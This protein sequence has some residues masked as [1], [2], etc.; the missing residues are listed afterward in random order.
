MCVCYSWSRVA[1]ETV[2]DMQHAPDELAMCLL[3]AKDIRMKHQHSTCR[4]KYRV[5]GDKEY[6]A[7]T[8]SDD[9][10]PSSLATE[11]SRTNKRARMS[12]VRASPQIRF[13]KYR[14]QNS[15]CRTF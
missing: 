5:V 1:C 8:R 3:K 15:V 10:D 4:G 13:V 2:V 9:S 11:R 6:C 14:Y 12:G 7:S